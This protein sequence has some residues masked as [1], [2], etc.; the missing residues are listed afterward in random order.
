MPFFVDNQTSTEL[1]QRTVAADEHVSRE[2]TE[3]RLRFVRHTLMNQKRK[4][5]TPFDNGAAEKRHLIDTNSNQRARTKNVCI[6]S[7][8]QSN[9]LKTPIAQ[10]NID[11]LLYSTESKR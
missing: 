3:N 5:L 9:D 8:H 2:S 11:N 7:K 6:Q 1:G 10:T 4:Q